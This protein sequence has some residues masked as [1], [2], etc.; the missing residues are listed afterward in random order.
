MLMV[1]L[2]ETL[3]RFPLVH[4]QVYSCRIRTPRLGAISRY[5]AFVNP[6]FSRPSPGNGSFLPFSAFGTASAL[7]LAWPRDGPGAGSRRYEMSL[8]INSL[9]SLATSLV[10]AL[11]A[12]SLFLSAAVGPVPVI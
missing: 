2:R 12:S 4:C 1:S 3:M 10:G 5:L 7:S 8:S 11:V 6:A 9:Q